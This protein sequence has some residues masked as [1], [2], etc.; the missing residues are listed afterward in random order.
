MKTVHLPIELDELILRRVEYDDEA[1]LFEYYGDPEVARFQFWIPRTIEQIDQIVAQQLETRLGD[2]GVPYM[3]VAV[4]KADGKV[5]G[6]CQLTITSVEDRQGE[7]GFAFNPRYSGRGLATRAVTAA[8]GFG[9][10]RLNLHRIV[11]AVDV[12][13]ERSWRLMERI[14]M[15]REAH[16]LH[17]ARGKDEW[18]DDYVYAVLESEWTALGK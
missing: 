5:I 1:D 16:F 11:A 12:R 9:F 6:D 8:I 13:N 15:R 2:P 18:I 14:G 17:D 3:M 4:L 7:I 10:A